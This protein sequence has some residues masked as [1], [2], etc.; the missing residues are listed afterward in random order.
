MTMPFTVLIV[1]DEVMIAEDIKETLQEVGY[2]DVYRAINFEQATDLLEKK[3]IDLVM[4]DINLNEKQSGVDLAEHINQNYHI[5]FIF[6]TSYSSQET[7]NQVKKTKPTAFLLKPYTENLLLASIE[8]ALFNYYTPQNL[9][10]TVTDEFSQ[11]ETD[12]ELVINGNLV[13]K[14]KKYFIKIPVEDILW[15]ESDKNYI[16]V[17]TIDRKYTI[18]GSLKKIMINL[19]ESFIKCHRQYVVNLNHVTGFNSNVVTIGDYEIPVSRNEHDLVL[20]KLKM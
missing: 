10:D 15:L 7:I 18:R 17:K 12:L 11:A 20:N 4:L 2:Q 19:P 8:I 9:P 3:S 16:D 5:P 6:L 14:D 1:D 13:I